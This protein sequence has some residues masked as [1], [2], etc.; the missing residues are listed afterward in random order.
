MFQSRQRLS[1]FPFRTADRHLDIGM[2]SVRAYMD[3]GHLH[4]QKARIV[5][6]EAD[7]FG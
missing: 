5:G 7:D 1:D 4:H 2:T 6:F 3:V